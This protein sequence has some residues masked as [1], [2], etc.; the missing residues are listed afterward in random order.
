[1][2]PIRNQINVRIKNRLAR[3]DRIFFPDQFKDICS[4]E[5]ALEILN[6]L[7]DKGE[8]TTRAQIY[9]PGGHICF[10]DEVELISTGWPCCGRKL[11]PKDA[12]TYFVLSREGD[13]PQEYARPREALE[14]ILDLADRKELREIYA[15]AAE[16]LDE[17]KIP[18]APPGT[19]KRP[20]EGW[21]CSRDDGHEGPCPTWP[22]T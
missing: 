18:A 11:D 7:A 14:R 20:P 8:L 3:N 12:A 1:M 19:C 10:D 4:T 2:K 5:V 13:P 17:K 16:A 22:R 21:Y 6:D 9:G 15:I